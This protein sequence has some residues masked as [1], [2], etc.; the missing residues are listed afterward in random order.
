MAG[1]IQRKA[2]QIPADMNG[3]QRARINKQLHGEINRQQQCIPKTKPVFDVTEILK[4]SSGN[5]GMMLKLKTKDHY[6]RVTLGSSDNEEESTH[7]VLEIIF[8]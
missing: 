8:Y 7:P 3:L 5:L 2:D 4:A 1:C 6:R